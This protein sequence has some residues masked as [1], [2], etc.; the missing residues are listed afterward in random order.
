MLDVLVELTKDSDS[1][2]RR[3]AV[4]SLGAFKE[5][6]AIDAVLKAFSD[7][8]LPVR[9]AAERAIAAISPGKE[10]LDGIGGALL[11]S[12]SSRASAVTALGLLNAV[13][14]SEKITGILRSSDGDLAKRCVVALG[15][16]K[17][18]QAWREVAA[19][20]GSEDQVMR[21]EVAKTLGVLGVGESFSVLSKLAND[22][23]WDVMKEALLSMG[24]IGD[25]A[26]VPDL[27]AAAKRVDK[28]PCE[29]RSY[30]CWGLARTVSSFKPGIGRWLSA[31]ALKKVVPT[32][33]GKDYDADCVR[34]SA[35]LALIEMGKKSK[36]A[37]A[38][39][40]SI[41]KEFGGSEDGFASTYVG[42]ALSDYVRQ[43]K[44]YLEGKADGLEPTPVPTTAPMLTVAPIKKR[45]K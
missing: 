35:V 3:L 15:R 16:L 31:L 12:P 41:L 30:A 29:V 37:K 32:D 10:V 42:V 23:D 43:I 8:A 39:A 9:S 34:S 40:E 14:Y 44:A 38:E 21:L 22:G 26:F 25:S 13:G 45:K 18:G 2:V 28:T 11:D 20:A 5:R 17:Y 33:A 27:L 24:R 6:S 36:K 19:K 7:E 1:E 4:L